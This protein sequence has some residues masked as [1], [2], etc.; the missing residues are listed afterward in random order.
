M[1]GL[2]LVHGGL[3]AGIYQPTQRRLLQAIPLSQQQNILNYEHDVVQ[4]IGIA[5]S[6]L[7]LYFIAQQLDLMLPIIGGVLGLL[8][9]G[10][11]ILNWR[12][13]SSYLRRLRTLVGQRKLQGLQINWDDVFTCRILE[14]QLQS[15]DETEVVRAFALLDETSLRHHEAPL[16]QLAQH[17]NPLVQQE[18]MRRLENSGSR[19][20]A[21]LTRQLAAE[22]DYLLVRAAAVRAN[23]S[24]VASNAQLKAAQS[25]LAHD[26]SVIRKGALCG[27]LNCD[28]SKGIQT[29]L[30]QLNHYLD[31]SSPKQRITGL[32]VI[33]AVG[34]S[35]LFRTIV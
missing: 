26:S 18:A 28:W 25:W 1:V 35:S 14:Q 24:L 7:A 9:V 29:A 13:A 33:E 5:S 23:C 27:L 4:P 21:A 15:V 11:M 19:Q 20:A 3:N 12:T 2:K 22:S 6:G 34:E 30:I 10:W 8:T 17:G 32:Q 16:L 31:S